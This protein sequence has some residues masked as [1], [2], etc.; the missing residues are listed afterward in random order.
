MGRKLGDHIT[1]YTGKHFYPMDPDPE[2]LDIEDIAHALSFICRGNGQVR[3]FYSVAEHCINCALEAEARGYS[4]RV[5]LAC[6]LHDASESYMSDVPRPFK[7]YLKDYQE[8]EERLLSCIYKTFLGSDLTEEEQKKVKEI[9]N[10]L[11]AHDMLHLL[12][13]GKTEELVQLKHPYSYGQDEMYEVDYNYR[14]LYRRYSEMTDKEY[15]AVQNRKPVK[16]SVILEAIEMA[17][18]EWDYFLDLDTMEAV[19]LADPYLTGEKEEYEEL[20]ELMDEEP[21]RFLRLPDKFEINDYSIMESFVY[22]LPEGRQQEQLKAA[23]QGRG[24]FR[25]FKD[26]VCALGMEQLWYSY[27]EDEH[28]KI[29]VKWCRENNLKYEE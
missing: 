9:D 26:T 12:G 20:T 1:T 5:A 17:N 22:M 29:A 10:D 28:K 11:L 24:A 7:K 18:D 21:E 27:E 19:W 4:R 23:I 2:D 3:M 15:V 13:E 8:M 6:L 25:R 16:L 14:E